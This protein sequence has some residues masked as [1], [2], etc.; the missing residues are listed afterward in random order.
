MLLFWFAMI[1][2]QNEKKIDEV[3]RISKTK[4]LKIDLITFEK[5]NVVHRNIQSAKDFFFLFV[6]IMSV[7]H[8]VCR[9]F[10]CR[11]YVLHPCTKAVWTTRKNSTKFLL[12]AP[13]L[14]F[15]VRRTKFFFF[16]VF[17]LQPLWRT[18]DLYASRGKKMIK[19]TSE[20]F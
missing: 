18:I 6:N 9:Y 15:F 13:S 7:R 14:S 16:S 12:T 19:A 3:S 8:F 10:V 1:C 17:F 4:K 11:H 5:K 2:N 20:D